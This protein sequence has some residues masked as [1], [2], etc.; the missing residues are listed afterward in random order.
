[1]KQPV[2]GFAGLTHLGLNSAV[3][4]AAKGFS[5]IGYHNDLE[6]VAQLNEGNLHVTEPQLRTYSSQRSCP[7]LSPQVPDEAAGGSRV[8]CVGTVQLDLVTLHRAPL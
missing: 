2:I 3:A 8:Q 7:L 4:S 5:V 1:M 6:L